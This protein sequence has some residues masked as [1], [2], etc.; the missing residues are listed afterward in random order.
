[1]QKNHRISR[2]IA[3]SMVLLCVSISCNP[4]MTFIV[5]KASHDQDDI[6]LTLIPYGIPGYGNQTKKL[7]RQQYDDFRQ[8]LLDL[9]TRLNTMTSESQTNTL[10]DEA[11]D[12]LNSYELLPGGMSAPLAKRFIRGN[13]LCV[14][15]LSIFQ[16]FIKE[17]TNENFTNYFCLVAGYSN[18]TQFWS[19]FM[20]LWFV[21]SNKM[22]F[23]FSQF[24][25]PVQ[26]ILFFVF[27]FTTLGVWGLDYLRALMLWGEIIFDGNT[28]VST[29][30]LNGIK[31]WN[32]DLYG[33]IIGFTGFKLKLGLQ[34]PFR[35][36]FIGSA[37]KIQVTSVDPSIYF[38]SIY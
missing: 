6:A 38:P 17:N 23:F 33:D 31:K 1:M 35:Y 36:F 2:G 13:N 12:V 7:T 29:L 11:I 14:D 22:N 26:I 24:S 19:T 4:V 3:V 34:D 37:M 5:V 25:L 30:G 18:L 20:L 28:S 9:N 21:L 27:Y 10:F 16:R 8:Y 32:G 15:K